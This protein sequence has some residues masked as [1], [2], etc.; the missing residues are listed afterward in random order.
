MFADRADLRRFSADNDMAAVTAFPHLD[1]ALFENF[2]DFH[3]VEQGTVAFFMTFFDGGYASELLCQ[4]VET[5]FISFPGH[6]FI[7]ICP[8]IVFTLG[9]VLQILGGISKFAKC[10]KPEFCVFFFIVG[11]LQEKIGNLLIAG[12]FCHRSKIGIFISRL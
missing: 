4:L 1:T 10:L 9:S 8:L 3:I 7:H 2:H 12:L 11:G 5:F 6:A